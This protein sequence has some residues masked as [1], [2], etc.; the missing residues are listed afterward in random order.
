MHIEIKPRVWLVQY[1][2]K[3]GLWYFI[4]HK[5]DMYAPAAMQKLYAIG[6]WTI[7]VKIENMHLLAI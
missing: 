2:W 3:Y 1:P 7:K 4:K 5:D 6:L